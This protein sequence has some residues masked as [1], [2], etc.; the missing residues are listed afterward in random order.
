VPIYPKPSLIRSTSADPARRSSIIEVR[1]FRY[2]RIGKPTRRF[3][4]WRV[5]ALEGGV[6]R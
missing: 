6:D 5:A 1:G 4:S 2:S 3:W